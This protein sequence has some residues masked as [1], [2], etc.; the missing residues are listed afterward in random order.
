MQV[1]R[2]VFCWVVSVTVG[3]IQ[4]MERLYGQRRNYLP[5]LIRSTTGSAS[6]VLYYFGLMYL[7]LADTVSTVPP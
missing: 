4:G 2:A 1:V 7:P 5:M 3:K 6:M